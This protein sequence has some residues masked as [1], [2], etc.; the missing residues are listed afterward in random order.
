MREWITKPAKL[1][2]MMLHG[3]D[4]DRR[5]PSAPE[6][7]S[8]WDD[9]AWLERYLSSERREFYHEVIAMLPVAPVCLLDAGC[10][11]GYFLRLLIDSNPPRQ[12]TEF[13][14]LDM[15]SAAVRVAT[16][17]CPEASIIHGSVYQ[18]PLA[19][20]TINLIVCMEVLEHLLEP[21]HALNEMMRT[22]QPG[23]HLLVSV[24]DGDIDQ[25]EGH[26]SFWGEVAFREFLKPYHLHTLVRIDGGRTFAAILSK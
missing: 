13:I 16:R 9:P 11:C 6:W 5:L 19:H 10:G 23:G 12:S 2:R 20:N 7:H 22:L 24:P 15:S 25:W 8:N 14:G 18:I 21:R 26:N 17:V 4:A 3:A 1:L